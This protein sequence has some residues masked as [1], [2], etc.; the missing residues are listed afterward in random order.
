MMVQ[1]RHGVR[2]V[3][4]IGK[5]LLS[6]LMLCCLTDVAC[7]DGK[8]DTAYDVTL[9]RLPQIPPGTVIGTEAPPGWSHLLLKTYSRPGAGDVKKLSP[10][11]DRLTRLL[12]T[13]IVADVR[14]QVERGD[15][16][17]RGKRYKLE[18]VA[19]G[20][21]TRIGDKDVI[22][23]PDTQQRLG[24]DLGLLARI[25]LSK[26]QEKLDDMVVVARSATFLVFDSP[27]FLAVEGQHKP[28]VLRYAVLVEEQTGRVNTLVWPVGRD[29]DGNYGEPLGAIQWLPANLTEDCL[30][31]IDGNEFCLG[32][33]TERAF[34][35]TSPP[36]GQK[37]IPMGD[38][39]KLLAARPRFSSAAAAELEAKLWKELTLFSREP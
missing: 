36:K 7:S 3:R 15:K 19:V 22:I 24:A 13:A 14:P 37:E 35:I 21:G 1:C 25:V 28:I 27:S 33:P 10:T 23:T 32:Q 11:A 12:F 16:G 8:S 38:D 17:E 5:M 29:A 26:A 30:L 34:A 9:R 4:L 39:L 20:L 6:V 31:H 18:K 2:G